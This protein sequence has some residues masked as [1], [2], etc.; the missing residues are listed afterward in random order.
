MPPRRC[1]TYAYMTV[2]DESLTH[3]FISCTL[4]IQEVGARVQR[5]GGECQNKLF[6]GGALYK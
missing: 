4:I 2:A 5:G 1:V 3:G 6:M